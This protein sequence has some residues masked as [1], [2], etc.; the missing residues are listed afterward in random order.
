[1]GAEAI[2]RWAKA[3]Y[4]VRLLVLVVQQT[5]GGF[6]N[7]VP[8]LH[9]MVA[10]GGLQEAKSRWIHRIKWDKDELMR[11]WR[12]AVIA[13]LA[14]AVALIS[15]ESEVDFCISYT[16]RRLLRSAPMRRIGPTGV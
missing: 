1:M 6:L 3:R 4:G 14:E 16:S 8:H 11:A 2:I 9:V 5:F 13:F 12:H 15:S 7:F 10:A